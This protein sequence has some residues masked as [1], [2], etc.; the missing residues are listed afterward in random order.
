MQDLMGG[1]CAKIGSTAMQS[2]T[3]DMLESGATE[4]GQWTEI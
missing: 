1:A 2:Q 3:P 4:D